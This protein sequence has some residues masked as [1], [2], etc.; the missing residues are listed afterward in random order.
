VQSI[1]LET[2]QYQQKW[3]QQSHS[4]DTNRIHKQALQCKPKWRRNKGW[5][6]KRWKDQLH[7]EG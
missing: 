1:V 5:R 7:I 6:R 4:M 3:L 2:E